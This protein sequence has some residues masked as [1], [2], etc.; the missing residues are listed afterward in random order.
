MRYGYVQRSFAVH[1][2]L[3]FVKQWLWNVI[4]IFAIVVWTCITMGLVFG[5]MKAAKILRV[6]EEVELKGLD[7]DTHGE[8]AYPLAAYGLGWDEHQRDNVLRL[9][10][11]NGLIIYKLTSEEIL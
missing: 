7:I 3:L 4:G 11:V 10:R 6:S 8:A 9:S 5:I 1:K 2:Y